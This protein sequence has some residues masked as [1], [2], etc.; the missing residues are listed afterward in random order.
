MSALLQQLNRTTIQAPSPPERILQ[1]GGGNFVRC[2]VG[3]IIQQYNRQAAKP[4]GIVVVKTT[5]RGDYRDWQKQDG[6]YHVRIRGFE[7]GSVVDH[8]ERIDCVSRI[9]HVHQAWDEFLATAQLPAIRYVVSNTTESGIRLNN[10]D[11]FDDHPPQEFPAKLTRWLYHRYVHF[12]GAPS[13]GCVF[14]PC[15]LLEANGDALLHAILDQADAWRLDRNFMRWIKEC[16]IFCNTLVDR[17]VPGIQKDQLPSVWQELGYKDAMATEGEPY[18]LWAIE[19]PE[20]VRQELPLD[21]TGL[22]VVYT[23]D[24]KP[25][26]TQKVRILNGA[27]TTMVPVAFLAGVETVRETIEH[28][29]LGPFVEQALREEIIPAMGGPAGPLERYAEVILDR[30]R[31][32]SINHRLLSISLNSVS[33]FRVRVLPSL[34]DYYQNIGRLPHRLVFSFACLLRFY[35]GSWQGNAIPL[36]DEEEVLKFMQ[37]VWEDCDDCAEDVHLLV[38]Q[39]LA[40]DRWWGR[41]LRKINGLSRAVAEHLLCIEN[42]GVLDCLSNTSEKIQSR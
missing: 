17:I 40:K 14:L 30:F 26:R 32:P 2:F 27:H 25:Y 5:D 22:N 31:N 21:Q 35:R 38:E 7:N 18:H 11:R 33:K 19:A 20:S 4:M 36:V 37:L 1:F 23:D 12:N 24:L 29:V 39:I 9:I 34:L 15:E 16:N 8:I 41:D 42:S 6:L 28:P 10:E 3:W 13:A